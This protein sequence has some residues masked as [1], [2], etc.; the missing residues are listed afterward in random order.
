MPKNLD[1]RD[2]TFSRPVANFASESAAISSALPGSHR[3]SAERI[4]PFTGS[5]QSLNSVNAAAGFSPVPGLGPAKEDLIDR[6]LEHVQ[7]AASA[8]GFSGS[9]E[10]AEFV[11]DPHVKRTGS[12]ESVV[13]LRQQY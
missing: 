1:T 8:L 10:K 2:F 13:N 11:P 3:V 7:L 6:A 9:G 5:A 4:N 12:G